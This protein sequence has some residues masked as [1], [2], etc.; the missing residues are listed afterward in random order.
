VFTHLI[1]LRQLLDLRPM[2][3]P[4]RERNHLQILASRRRADIPRPCAHIIHNR[5]LQPRNQEVCALVD[6]L[7]SNTG[8]SVED[9]GACAALDVVDGGL[10][11]GGADGRGNDPAEEGGGQGG[12]CYVVGGANGGEAMGGKMY[13]DDRAVVCALRRWWDMIGGY[14]ATPRP[15]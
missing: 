15:R 7:L 4:Q 8:H 1:N 10:H 11:D 2:Q 6:D 14:I 3:H 13:D 9:D 12:H 5:P